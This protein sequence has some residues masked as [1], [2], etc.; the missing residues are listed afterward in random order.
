MDIYRVKFVNWQKYFCQFRNH[1]YVSPFQSLLVKMKCHRDPFWHWF[2]FSLRKFSFSVLFSGWFLQTTYSSS[3][4]YFFFLLWF[5]SKIFDQ[6]ELYGFPNVWQLELFPITGFFRRG[7]IFKT[8]MHPSEKGKLVLAPSQCCN[9][10]ITFTWRYFAFR[11]VNYN[12]YFVTIW[13][14][15]MFG[16]D[17]R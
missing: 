14:Y 17:T 5:T 6:N 7:F 12:F 13:S 1:F 2:Y 8:T 15:L 4:T 11:R 10:A 16:S 3:Y 9:A